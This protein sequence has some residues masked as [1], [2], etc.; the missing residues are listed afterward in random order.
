MQGCMEQGNIDEL[1][2]VVPRAFETI[3]L[4]RRHM[5]STGWEVCARA[6]VRCVCVCVCVQVLLEVN[7]YIHTQTHTHTG[8][9]GGERGRDLQR[10]HPRPALRRQVSRCA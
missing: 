8:A 6:C 10:S 9:A 7:I 5:Q 1:R 2:G 3:M 4:I